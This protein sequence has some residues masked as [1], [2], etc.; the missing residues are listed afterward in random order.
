MR[1]RWI[2]TLAVALLGL[3]ASPAPAPSVTPGT[4]SA[5]AAPSAKLEDLIATLGIGLRLPPA[6]HVLSGNFES[7]TRALV[8]APEDRDGEIV[9]LRGEPVN[10]R[11]LQEF[12]TVADIPKGGRAVRICNGTQDGWYAEIPEDRRAA[13]AQRFSGFVVAAVNA[14]NAVAAAYSRRPS[15]AEDAAVRSAVLNLCV[16]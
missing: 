13:E 6:W 9:T 15:V 8:L 1:L 7:G 3:G 10:G 12:T 4:G 11:S 16:R 2:T 5:T 14:T